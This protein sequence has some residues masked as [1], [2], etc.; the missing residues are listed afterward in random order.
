M[1]SVKL[2][3][4]DTP[5]PLPPCTLKSGWVAVLHRG[6]FQR[7]VSEPGTVLHVGGHSSF[8]G[9]EGSGMQVV[10]LEDSEIEPLART[11]SGAPRLKDVQ[12][13]LQ[14]EL[15]VLWEQQGRFDGPYDRELMRERRPQLSHL[16]ATA[17]WFDAEL[18]K[19]LPFGF[20]RTSGRALVLVAEQR[21]LGPVG[22]FDR[23]TYKMGSVWV[24]V[25][26][27]GVKRGYL[28]WRCWLQD[29]AAL[30]IFRELGG[31]PA[32]TGAPLR[33]TVDDVQHCRVIDSTGHVVARF[34]TERDDSDQA[35][36][37]GIRDYFGWISRVPGLVPFLGRMFTPEGRAERQLAE[38]F[39]AVLK[40]F[41]FYNW[42]VR[43]A[44]KGGIGGP[45]DYLQGGRVRQ[46]GIR[47][48]PARLVGDYAFDEAA[49]GLRGIRG[50]FQAIRLNEHT[51]FGV[52][53]PRRLW[54]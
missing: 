48:D 26:R 24:P 7:E 51:R 37:D 42:G 32:A 31:L 17:V 3:L 28:L 8:R 30:R 4:S 36:Y 46:W 29:V 52:L 33:R 11:S 38:L 14:D 5:Y 6:V 13:A 41:W 15:S 12:A 50:E 44:P 39:Q 16:D 34:A 40:R 54:L 49:L 2:A 19:K 43:H 35:R 53:P 27:F 47:I 25:S 23:Y 9:K 21:G 45:G 10:A 1:S 18:D 20:R 22:K